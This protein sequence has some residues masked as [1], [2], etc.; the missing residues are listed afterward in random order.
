MEKLSEFM[1]ANEVIKLLRQMRHIIVPKSII[2]RIRRNIIK[3][4][5]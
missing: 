3:R 5:K 4:L 2:S 1:T